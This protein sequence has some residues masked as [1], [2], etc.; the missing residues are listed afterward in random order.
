MLLKANEA[1]EQL[2]KRDIGEVKA[3]AHPPSAV[4]KVMKALMILSQLKVH[5][6]CLV[7]VE[8]RV[9]SEGKE[10]TWEEAKKDLANVDFIKTLTVR[11]V[12]LCASSLHRLR[13]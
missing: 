5:R 4:E 1:L 3:Y 2:T 11:S 9:V 13:L 10:D 8:F 7:L 12:C 6:E